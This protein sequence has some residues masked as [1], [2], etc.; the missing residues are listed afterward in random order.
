MSDEGCIDSHS[1][2]HRLDRCVSHGDLVTDDGITSLRVQMRSLAQTVNDSGI[3][4]FRSF[5]VAVV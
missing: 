2:R 5:E 4:S 1:C 3:L